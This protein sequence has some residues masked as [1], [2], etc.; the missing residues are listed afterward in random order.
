M[1]SLEKVIA[2]KLK[3]L[4][5]T[6]S[7]AESCTGGAICSKLVSNSGASTYFKGGVVCYS[8]ESKVNILGIEKGLIDNKSVVSVEVADIMAKKVKE[9]FN[10][11]F[12][13]ATTG[14]IG[15]T[16]GDSDA[17]IGKVFI[18]IANDEIINTLEFDLKGDRDSIIKM[19]VEKAFELLNQEL[20]G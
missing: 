18:S 9:M 17:P 15:P 2:S 7:I 8:T 1:S 6:L 12:S 14:N 20:H 11:D 10:T 3:E 5:K 4:N 19:V 16:K 13:I